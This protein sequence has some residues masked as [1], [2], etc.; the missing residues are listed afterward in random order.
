MTGRD[1]K[2]ADGPRS[3]R[4]AILFLC[5]HNAAKSLLAV[6]DF[7]RLAAARGLAY[8]AA[9]AG[10]EPAGGPAPAVVAAMRAE[11]IDVAGYRPRSVTAE[12]IVGASRVVS[13]GC[14]VED[15]PASPA[16][17]ERWDDLPPVSQDLETARR[18]IRRRLEV[19]VDE[20]AAEQPPAA[21]A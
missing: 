5:P 2:V 6:A 1:D 3:R 7:D 8:R 10:T 12:D 4:R 9:S 15:L 16:R 19:L 17:I 14:D 21:G 20:L 11:G 13:L 18:V